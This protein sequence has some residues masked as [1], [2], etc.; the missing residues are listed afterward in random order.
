MAP[1]LSLIN[2]EFTVNIALI[3]NFK[4]ILVHDLFANKG[5][6]VFSNHQ[7]KAIK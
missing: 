1:K 3:E 4:V 6:D 7:N 2:L 5:F